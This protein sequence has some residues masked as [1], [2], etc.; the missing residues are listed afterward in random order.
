MTEE[1]SSPM[2]R[3]MVFAGDSYYPAGGIGDFRGSFDTE[4]EARSAIAKMGRDW[5]ECLDTSTGAVTRQ[6]TGA[7]DD[8]ETIDLVTGAVHRYEPDWDEIGG[9]GTPPPNF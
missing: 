4:E 6:W 5:H 2:K 7:D 3:F 8:T 9:S 1:L